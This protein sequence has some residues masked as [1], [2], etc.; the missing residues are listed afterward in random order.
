MTTMELEMTRG[1]LTKLGGMLHHPQED[2]AYLS[3]P[4]DLVEK[5]KPSVKKNIIIICVDTNLGRLGLALK[6]SYK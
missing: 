1:T 4:N 5:V 3:K 2:N 6:G